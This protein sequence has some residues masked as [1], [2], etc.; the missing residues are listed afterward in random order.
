MMT[1]TATMM[2]I[3]MKAIPIRTTKMSITKLIMTTP[4]IQ[5]SINISNSSMVITKV[6]MA[7]MMSRK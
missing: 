5:S 4:D 7:I 2:P 3:S 1:A 6:L